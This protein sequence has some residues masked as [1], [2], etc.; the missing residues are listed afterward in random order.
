MLAAAAQ[1]VVPEAIMKMQV[2]VAV[3]TTGKAVL[4]VG[5][6]TNRCW[7]PG[8]AAALATLA[9][10]RLTAYFWVVAAAQAVP[11]TVRLM[12]RLTQTT[13][14]VAVWGR[15]CAHQAHLAEVLW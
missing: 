4:A 2:V 6:G 10:W 14:L 8:D 15:V 1:M 9:L 12:L 7:T 5:P 13:E 3:E 11:T